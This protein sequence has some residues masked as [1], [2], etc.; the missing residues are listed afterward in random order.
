MTVRVHKNAETVVAAEYNDEDV[1]GA[2]AAA[3][4]SSAHKDAGC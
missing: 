1:C 3:E 4:R 2:A